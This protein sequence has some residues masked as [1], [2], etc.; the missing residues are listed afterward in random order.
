MGART[1]LFHK[2]KSCFLLPMALAGPLPGPICLQEHSMLATSAE[3]NSLFNQLGGTKSVESVVE[4]F[5][6]RVLADPELAPFFAKTNMKWLKLRQAQFFTQA[7]GGPAIY[8][9][10]PM[11][12][13]H[14]KMAVEERHFQ[15]VAQHLAE[16]LM[17]IGVSKAHIDEV[18][19]LIVPLKVDIV[20]VG[21]G[22][23]AKG[24]GAEN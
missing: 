3:D 20:T 17:S 4:E 14:A 13:S 9:G 10:K 23:K 2:L 7:L 15:K 8:K 5:Y 19:R 21:P 11:K 18:L 1:L 22:A 24:A 16:T 6:K 12:E